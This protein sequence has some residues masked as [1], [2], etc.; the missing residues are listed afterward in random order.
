MRRVLRSGWTV[1]ALALALL[2]T[3]W[4][5]WDYEE[6]GWEWLSQTDVVICAAAAAALALW[7]M[8]DPRSGWTAI[9]TPVTST[10]AVIAVAGSLQRGLDPQI[11]LYLAFALALAHAAAAYAA[12]GFAGWRSS[13]WSVDVAA[14]ALLIATYMPWTGGPAVA[15]DLFFG[16]WPM[17]D[18]ANAWE[19]LE[20]ADLPLLAALVTTLASVHFTRGFA[21]P[22]M[23][24]RASALAVAAVAVELGWTHVDD[25]VNFEFLYGAPIGLACLL[26]L[27]GT[28][29]SIARAERRFAVSGDLREPGRGGVPALD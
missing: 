15:I 20:Y 21:D 13:D 23:P 10:I 28:T 27:L 2:G 16:P 19:W 17:D 24:A 9:V 7:L 6:S 29:V 3:L 25:G 4:L 26:M 5:P 18:H 22:W 11:G 1:I 8:E 14:G 12:T